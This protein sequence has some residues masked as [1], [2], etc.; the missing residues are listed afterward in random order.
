MYERRN[1]PPI[2]ASRFR[3]RVFI[4]VLAALCLFIG[5]VLVGAAGFV[6]FE[7]MDWPRGTLNATTLISGLGVAEM[8]QTPGAKLFA[9]LFALYSG[10]VFVAMSGIVI[11]PILHRL[12]HFFHKDGGGGQSG[13]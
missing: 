8:P 13:T 1:E 10:F 3:L 12:L 7:G 9:S 11:A 5:S 2:S 6:L 4:H